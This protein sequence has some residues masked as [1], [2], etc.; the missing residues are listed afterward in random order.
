MVVRRCRDHDESSV[1]S[2]IIRSIATT[3]RAIKEQHRLIERGSGASVEGHS[4]ALAAGSLLARIVAIGSSVL[5][6]QIEANNA[7][8]FQSRRGA[9]VPGIAGGAVFCIV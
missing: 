1:G 6:I 4:H 3:E 8:A 7:D 9:M 5:G 2:D